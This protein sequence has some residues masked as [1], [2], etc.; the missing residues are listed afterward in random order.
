MIKLASRFSGILMMAASLASASANAITSVATAADL[1]PNYHR[2]ITQYVPFS[3]AGPYVGAT[4]GYEWASI[5]NNPTHPTG[6]AGGVE[7]GINWQTANFIYGGEADINFSAAHDT[8]APWQFSNPWFGTVRGRAGMPSIM[9]CC[10]A[11]PAS[12]MAN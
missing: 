7:T 5:D 10:S 12:V 3:W 8:S 2:S 4:L 1:A 6:V 9:C 11:P